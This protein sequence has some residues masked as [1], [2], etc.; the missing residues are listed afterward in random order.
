MGKSETILKWELEQAE[1]F[2]EQTRAELDA[3]SEPQHKQLWIAASDIEP[4]EAHFLRA[5]IP[6]N[7]L[8]IIAGD[9]GVGKSLLE[10][11]LA[12]AIS[13]GIVSVLDDEPN[14]YAEA[15]KYKAGR[16][17]LLN[18][19]DSFAHV[20]SKRLTDCGADMDMILTLNPESDEQIYIDGALFEAI[21]QIQPKLVIIDP[22]Q[23]YIPR[24][25]QMERRNHM[26]QVLAP[27]QKC[28]EE[29][30][31]AVVVIMHT[32]KR[33]G[34]S[35]RDKLADSA[36]LWD[37]AR[38]V[39]IMGSTR[40]EFDTRYISHEKSS[41]GKPISTALCCIDKHGL[42]RTGSCDKKDYDY[43]YERDR[44]G[45]GRP[46]VQREEA[47]DVILD[48]LSSGKMD[49]KTLESVAKQNGI[50]KQTFTRARQELEES[51]QI[52]KIKSGSGKDYRVEYERI[53][54]CTPKTF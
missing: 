11:N 29:C 8:T 10:C 25:T 40:D 38:S 4:K 37:I 15:S 14:N 36:D 46:P 43:V 6:E 49:S 35:G 31:T 48:I 13:T 34:A 52:R 22:L 9:G 47:R 1:K 28:A 51:K 23:A 7:N 45:G 12:A 2:A 44:H 33:A 20:I 54:H 18:A 17:L 32:N 30:N 53:I 16:V 42:Y 5:G 3:M 50:S 39:F 24:G 27:L 21:R 26:R 19:E 41:Y